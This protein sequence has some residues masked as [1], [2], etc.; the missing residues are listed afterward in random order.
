[1]KKDFLVKL[2]DEGLSIRDIQKRTNKGNGTV[3]YWLK[4]H[5][6]KTKNKP[7]NKDNKI[8]WTENSTKFCFKCKEIK[9]VK[10]F[11]KRKSKS[12]YD[13]YAGYCKKCSNEYHT[14]RVKEVKI[15]MVHH[16]GGECIR[17]HLKLEDSHYCVF[18]FHHK[19][20]SEKDIKFNKIKYQKWETIEKELNKCDLL[21]SNCHRLTHAEIEGW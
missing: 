19:D 2:I 5:N 20:P 13:E 7:F 12:R 11:Y 4:K 14:K 17:C 1:M 3:R 18:E 8:V 21:C 15:K 6:L 10:D 16:K 9:S